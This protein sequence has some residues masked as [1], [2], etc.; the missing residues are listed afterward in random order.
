MSESFGA[1]SACNSSSESSWRRRAEDEGN[2]SFPPR[3][4]SGSVLASWFA[5]LAKLGEA[6]RRA[7]LKESRGLCGVAVPAADGCSEATLLNRHQGGD[8]EKR[9][10]ASGMR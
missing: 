4:H 8:E 6:R 5:W 9:L 10:M 7:A 2:P 1:C 3:R